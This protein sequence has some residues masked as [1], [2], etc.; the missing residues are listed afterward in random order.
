MNMIFGDVTFQD[1][2]I[3]G[4][5]NLSDQ[6]TNTDGHVSKENRFAVFGDPY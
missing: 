3:K 2:H 1:F 4:F 5:A 6:I